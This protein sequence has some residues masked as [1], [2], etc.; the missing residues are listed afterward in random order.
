MTGNFLHFYVVVKSFDFDRDTVRACVFDELVARVNSFDVVL[1]FKLGFAERQ[2][3]LIEIAVVVE[4]DRLSLR[5]VIRKRIFALRDIVVR[6]L[7]LDKT[8]IEL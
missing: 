5:I 4:Y 1:L 6:V 8:G 3:K 2:R 7:P